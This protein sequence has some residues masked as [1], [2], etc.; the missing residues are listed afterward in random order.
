MIALRGLVSRLAAIAAAFVFM[1]A[2][3]GAQTAAPTTIRFITSPSED[4]LPFWYAQSKDMFRAV[5]LNIIVTKSPSGAISTQGVIGGVA[6]MGRASLSSLIA[7]HVRGIPFVLVA[8]SAIHR[9]ATSV[10]SAILVATNSQLKTPLDLQGKTISCTA[11]GDIGYLGLRAMI[12]AQGGD[13]ST[14]KWVEIPISAVAA[15]LEQGRVDASVTAEPYM[16][17][18]LAGGKVRMLVDMLDGYPGEILEGAYFSTREFAAAN[19]DALARFANVMRQAS[20]YTNAHGNELI[21]LLVANTG[22]EPEVAAR[23]KRALNGINFDP[24]QVQPVIDIAAKYKVLPRAFDA[25]EMFLTPQP[26]AKPK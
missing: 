18:D 9:H 26:A 22:M 23:M 21:S 11:I 14:I 8:P 6:D 1:S 2:A 15:A 7:A 3:A 20:I 25:R 24:S 16:S 13:S 5:G 4:L 19:T 12:D 17:R 10:N